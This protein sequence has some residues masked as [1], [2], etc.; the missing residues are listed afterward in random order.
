MILA[1]WSGGQTLVKIISGIDH[2]VAFALLCFVGFKMLWEARHPHD[3]RNPPDPFETKYLALLAVAT[4]LDA[5]ATGLSFSFLQIA[6][7]PAALI[8]GL[9]AFS[10]TVA[11]IY[12]GMR[13]GKLLAQKAEILGGL[14]LIAIGVKILAE[15]I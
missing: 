8:V 13:C 11:G 5:L 1:G 7:V 10:F 3:E 4:S 15:H 9:S 2:W 6:I 14:I 12:A